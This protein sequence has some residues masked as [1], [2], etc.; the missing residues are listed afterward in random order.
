MPELITIDR[1]PCVIGYYGEYL[2]NDVNYQF[3]LHQYAYNYGIIII[4]FAVNGII[5]KRS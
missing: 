2:W 4:S 3:N 5:I 1:I